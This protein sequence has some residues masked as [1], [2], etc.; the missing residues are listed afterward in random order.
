MKKYSQVKINIIILMQWNPFR[1][2]IAL[3]AL[4]KKLTYS[5]SMGGPTAG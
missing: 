3:T 4:G 1:N 5:F 2:G